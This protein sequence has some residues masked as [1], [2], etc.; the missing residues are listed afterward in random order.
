M[1]EADLSLSSNLSR[2]Q[3]GWTTSEVVS[4]VF[5]AGIALAAPADQR[6]ASRVVSLP[7]AP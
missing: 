2:P 7:G 4:D 1:R 5:I 3:G 6:W